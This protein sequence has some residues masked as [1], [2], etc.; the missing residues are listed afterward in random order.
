MSKIINSESFGDLL[1]VSFIR[2]NLISKNYIVV[3]YWL[4]H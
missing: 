2:N 3:L 1:L 4:I